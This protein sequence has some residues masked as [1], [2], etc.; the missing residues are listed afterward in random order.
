VDS[1]SYLSINSRDVDFVQIAEGSG[2]YTIGVYGGTPANFSLVVTSKERTKV[3]MQSPKL[4]LSNISSKNLDL[5]WW[6]VSAVD[7]AS[8]EQWDYHV[9]SLEE[10]TEEPP[11][12][13]LLHTP[14]GME[15]YGT[16]VRHELGIQAW[17]WLIFCFW[18]RSHGSLS[19]RG[20]NR[21]YFARFDLEKRNTPY[22]INVLAINK[23]N[24]LIKVAYQPIFLRTVGM[25]AFA[26][27]CVHLAQRLYKDF[28]EMKR[29]KE[30]V[31][32]VTKGAYSYLKI[33]TDFI[34]EDDE[35]VKDNYYR[36]PEYMLKF[37]LISKEGMFDK[38]EA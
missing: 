22:S 1:Y 9:Y 30:Y 33:N 5:L 12:D 6:P 14:C 23:Q 27:Y 3:H 19:T 18:Q 21:L 7:L 34:K 28:T 29:D 36:Q 8:A 15:R 25:S 37:T 26:S 2:T 16:L 17:R 35:S 31:G 38:I 24:P 4:Q 32:K 11:R 13:P 10:Q 20:V